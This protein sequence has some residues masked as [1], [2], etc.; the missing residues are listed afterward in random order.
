M[1]RIYYIQYNTPSLINFNKKLTDD[2]YPKDGLWSLGTYHSYKHNACAVLG[3][4][5]SK[6]RSGCTHAPNAE[7]GT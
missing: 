2:T 7:S 4:S 5:T 3:L 6:A 1:G